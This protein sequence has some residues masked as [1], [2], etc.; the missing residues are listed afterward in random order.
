MLHVHQDMSLN[1]MPAQVCHVHRGPRW[2]ML[3]E[4]SNPFERQAANTQVA[5]HPY[6]QQCCHLQSQYWILCKGNCRRTTAASLK[7]MWSVC[8][9]NVTAGPRKYTI[10]QQLLQGDTLTRVWAIIWQNTR[11]LETWARY[12]VATR[13]STPIMLGAFVYLKIMR[14]C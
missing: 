7:P 14:Q 3:H 11:N 9:G 8:W 6:W 1:V 5:H 13:G 10:M 2:Q 12:R 4:P